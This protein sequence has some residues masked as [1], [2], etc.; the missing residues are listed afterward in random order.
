MITPEQV[1]M[2]FQS[3]GFE[4]NER[5][6]NDI[7]FWTLRPQSE[8]IKLIEELRK[9]RMEINA[10][11]DESNNNEE[12]ITKNKKSLSRLSDEEINAL[13]DEYGLPSPEPEWARNNLPNDPQK[14]RKILEAQRKTVDDLIK[15]E[16]KNM[17]NSSPEVPKMSQKQSALSGPMPMT[18]NMG[19]GGP[20]TIPEGIDQSSSSPFFMGDHSIVKITNPRNPNLSTLW[21]VDQKRKILRPF[22]SDEAFQNTFEDPESA[23]NAIMT[24]ST[25]DLGPGGALEGFKMLNSSQGIRNDG[26]MDDIDFTPAQIAKR[27]NK[28]SDPAG[29]NKALS[30]LDGLFSNILKGRKQEQ[31]T[32]QSIQ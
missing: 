17:I 24:L 28:P 3:F 27:Y 25:K 11:E 21:L 23:N 31:P 16:M 7:G 18:P 10:K 1:A 13:F 22:E 30:I 29:E 9:R 20:G 15:K 19:M 14:I 26:S 8:G 12:E 32:G 2:A 5:G 4:P 6:M